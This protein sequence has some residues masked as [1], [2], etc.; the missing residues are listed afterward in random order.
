MKDDEEAGVRFIRN[1]WYVAAWSKEL[2][3]DSPIG[4]LIIGEP[5]VLYRASD[6]RPACLED[7]CPHRRAPLSMGQVIGDNL[8]CI[9][10]GLLFDRTGTCLSVPGSEAVP[11]RC[12]ARSFPVEERHG[13]IWVWMGD[14]AK[15]DPS[16]IPEIASIYGDHFL[17]RESALDYD[18]NYQLI[19][20]NLCDLSHLDYSHATTL[21]RAS[22]AKWSFDHPTIKPIE[23][24][25]LIE[26]WL[27]QDESL[28]NAR[29]TDTFSSYRFL[30]PGLFLMETKSFPPGVA[31]AS[32][33]GRPDGDPVFHQIDQQA[34]TPQD[35]KLSRYLFGVGLDGR[36]G[37]PEIFETAFEIVKAAFFE[38]KAI[39][40][41]Q[42]RIWDRT[43]PS[44]RMGFIAQDK[45]PAMVRKIIA[46]RLRAEEAAAPAI[47]RETV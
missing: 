41:G 19:H 3:P 22:G 43:D 30:L 31:A 46:D 45:A 26:R 33:Y 12:N 47:E 16:A 27:K 10:H 23:N 36:R 44:R 35:A 1:L 40:E 42:Q 17:N 14:P 28:H 2:G 25:V 34:V 8:Q 7:R 29:P 6:G 13:W 11:P 5:L 32:G 24:G 15:A 20:D 21:G 37:S 18:A 39:I 4:R 9:Y 38:D